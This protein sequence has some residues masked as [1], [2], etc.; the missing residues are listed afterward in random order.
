M[1]Q[2]NDIINDYLNMNS[3]DNSTGGYNNPSGSN[4]NSNPGSG[5]NPG[6][7]PGPSAGDKMS[8]NYLLDSNS[9]SSI[10]SAQIAEYL[11][12]KRDAVTADR[13]F[14]NR[15][16]CYVNL[17]DI[18]ITFRRNIQVEPING[19]IRDLYQNNP[20]LFYKSPGSTN[21]NNIIRYYNDIR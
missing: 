9:D 1:K 14:Y 8:I 19:I 15:R 10:S 18:G 17:S 5:P 7:G 13:V 11:T 20:H 2:L 12:A 3:T 6:P 21:V 16:S 4:N